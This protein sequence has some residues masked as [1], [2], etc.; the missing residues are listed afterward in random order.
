MAAKYANPQLGT[1]VDLAH[2]IQD[3]FA[4]VSFRANHWIIRYDGQVRP[5]FNRLIETSHW[6]N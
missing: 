2:G 6:H 5:F 1:I 3:A 4:G